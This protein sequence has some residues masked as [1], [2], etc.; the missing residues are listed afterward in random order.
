MV[1]NF[2]KYPCIQYCII[3]LCFSQIIHSNEI[4][5]HHLISQLETY[6][7][8][9]KATWQVPGLA[10]GVIMDGKIIFSKGFG[11]RK[12]GFTEEINEQTVFQ[13]ASMSKNLLA[14]L[15]AKLAEEKK[16]SFD[17]PVR[18]YIPQFALHSK[19]ATDAFTIK[20]LISHNSGLPGFSG[21]TLWTLGVDE[22]TIIAKLKDIPLKHPIRTRYAYQNQLFGL[23]SKIAEITSGQSIENLYQ[24]YLFNPLGMNTA[25]ADFEAVSPSLNILHFF[26]SNKSSPNIA[27]PHDI[28]QGEPRLLPF[29]ELNYLFAGSTGVS[30]SLKDALKWMQMLLDKGKLNN[31][32]ILKEESIDLLRSPNVEK[33]VKNSGF[34]PQFPHQRYLKVQYGMGHF[35]S[36][37]GTS[38]K[39]LQIL[40]HMGGFHGVRSL[41][42]ICPER[43]LGIVILTNL[44]ST[45]VS[46]APEAIANKFLDL[47]LGFNDID[48]NTTIKKDFDAL[49]N[50]NKRYKLKERL[51]NPS[52]HLSLA[53]YEGTY[54]N[55]FY[56]P[57]IIQVKENKLILTIAG[58]SVELAHFNGN[59]FFFEGHN[60]SKSLCENSNG[61]VYFGTS[62]QKDIDIL[63][64]YPMLYEGSED[65]IFK[66][67]ISK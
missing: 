5:Q 41:I 29:S 56:G 64:I 10:V 27:H 52:P 18:K 39:S 32:R 23:A 26:N 6:I 40:S 50:E 42:S 34:D 60:I 4:S 25:H 67:E 1:F 61:Y 38:D 14:H 63:Q 21:D 31:V 59:Q 65:G 45:R 46:F 33:T 49:K 47:V 3:F 12:W 15:I 36:T 8:D 44:G 24:Q 13:I 35:I 17:D 9:V 48:W 53:E 28:Y 58:K 51:Q 11:V 62:N 20:D 30:L 22:N 66:K 55:S 19:D 54:D 2:K 43:K 57:C 37:Y 7:E 16:L